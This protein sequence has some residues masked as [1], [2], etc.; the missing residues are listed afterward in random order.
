MFNPLSRILLFTF[1][2]NFCTPTS[3]GSICTTHAMD[4]PIST[5][6][7][8]AVVINDLFF[9]NNG[10]SDLAATNPIMIITI[11]TTI[12]VIILLLK[13]SHMVNPEGDKGNRIKLETGWSYMLCNQNDN[14][15]SLFQYLSLIH[16][17][18]PT[19]RT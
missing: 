12:T 11:P 16:I 10:S 6:I 7:T 14:L 1:P 19:R 3:P 4:I 18:E 9:R 5:T 8:P 15:F 2:N 13:V 17:Y